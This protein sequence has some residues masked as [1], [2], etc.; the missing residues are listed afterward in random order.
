MV[1]DSALMHWK[2]VSMRFLGK[3]LSLR[4]SSRSSALCLWDFRQVPEI[5]LA[6][7]ELE[8]GA[9]VLQDIA[10]GVSIDINND[11]A[12]NVYTI[13]HIT[14]YPFSWFAQCAIQHG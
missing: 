1:R 2:G 3:V 13:H 11:Y 12:C 9:Y 10:A 8:N 4:G 6:Y 5:W 14:Y 7:R